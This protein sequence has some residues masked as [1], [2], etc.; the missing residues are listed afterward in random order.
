MLKIKKSFS[1]LLLSLLSLL[2]FSQEN[3]NQKL[4]SL[5]GE[6]EM[7]F[8]RKYTSKV[9]VPGIHNDPAKI[10]NEVLWYK[11]EIKLPLGKWT[12]ATIQL[13]G[14]RFKPQVYINGEF[15][16]EK[17]GGMAPVFFQL[18][19]KNIKPGNT[20]TLEIALASLKNVSPTDASYTP[21]ADQW[22]SDVSSSLWD[23]VELNLH[24]KV[25][26]E[27][28]IPFINYNAQNVSFK[29]DLNGETN[30]KGKALLQIF[31]NKGKILI[32]QSKF[33]SGN[34]D[35]VN[36]ITKGILKSWGPKAPNLYRVQLT[37]FDNKNQLMDRYKIPFGIKKFEIRNKKFYLNNEPLVAKGG[38]VVWHRWVRSK[39]GRELGYDSAWFKRNIIQL[40]K[41]HGA[42]YLRFH[43][44]LPPEKF[45]DMCDEL[46]LVVQY[47]WNFFHGMPAS[48]ESLLIQYKSWL[49]LAMRHPSVSLIHPYN[50]TVGDQLKTVWAAL[51]KLLPDYPALVLEDRDVIHIHK[52]WWSMFENLGLYYD[53]ANVFPKAIM[54]DEFGGNYLNENGDLGGYPSLKESFL[55]FLGRKNTKAERLEFQAE[56]NAR[57]AEYWR[58]IG[59]AGFAPFCALGSYED[60]NTWFLGPL[61]DGKPKPVWDALTASFSPL[62]VSIDLWDKNFEPNQAIRLPIYLFNDEAKSNMLAVAITV[63]DTTGKVVLKENLKSEVSAFN[64]KVIQV[65][66]NLPGVNGDYI[67]KA[68]LLNRPPE[69]KYP[70]ISKWKIHVFKAK[71]P[72]NIKNV[73]VGISQK[74]EELKH[75]LNHLNIK[76][77]DLS[78]PSANLLLTSKADW[79][80]F[81]NGNTLFSGVL[82]NSISKGKS[83]VMLDVGDRPLGQGY[84]KN[85]GDLGPL[86]GVASV[87]NPKVN[88]YQLFNGVSL[89][90]KE[91]AEPESY[92]HPDRLN[93]ALWHNLPDDYTRIW[94]G[95]RGGLIV[96]AAD[97]EFKGLS[98]DAF[99][100][101]WK[102]RGAEEQKVKTAPYYAYEL[103]GFYEFSMLPNNETIKKKL[104]D[105]IYFL[106][107]DAPSLSTS[108][109]LNTP[110][111]ITDLNKNYLD[112]KNGLADSF[113][114]LANSAKNLTQTPVALIGFG[115]GKGKLIVSQLLTSGRLAKG[116]GE[117]GFYGIRYDEAA[118]QYVLNM[119]SL[120]IK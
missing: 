9:N 17:E 91:T 2:C 4:V 12:N 53:D 61:K 10:S 38:T 47:E 8:G 111:L 58:R 7:G 32:T 82:E 26:I 106:V 94:N 76:T 97:M 104:K 114:P 45:L 21:Q 1:V 89:K 74:E 120:A 87:Y 62:S 90:F 11:K 101:Q 65:S 15:V 41:D 81:A 59:A 79:D 112:S 105:K 31:D 73:I 34:R 116:Y 78:N 49:D 69:I 25:S 68:E 18:N 92:I 57:V 43:L 102:L 83:V 109:N 42:N 55:R 85:A 48:E 29:F 13:K 70:V 16:E 50:E 37:L 75:F 77:V 44:G 20:I 108:L 110:V 23:G 72:E 40:S 107:Q 98:A 30:F 39:E 115:K 46:G 56:S 66:L 99:V 64:K 80:E 117:D 118:V 63:E 6:W 19:N 28:V 5:N 3:L 71:I 96:P 103:Q 86:Q 100:T 22:R 36:V 119:M 113:I 33:I 35:S 84:P 93:N 52:Y 54:A 88:V 51:D 95:L 27:R 60:G 67:I 24:G 14:A